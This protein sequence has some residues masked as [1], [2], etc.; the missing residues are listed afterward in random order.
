[1]RNACTY[2]TKEAYKESLQEFSET[3]IQ[4]F[5]LLGDNKGMKYEKNWFIANTSHNVGYI[6][7]SAYSS[8]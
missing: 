3:I 5:P 2:H 6:Q 7:F 8:R 4:K 1:M